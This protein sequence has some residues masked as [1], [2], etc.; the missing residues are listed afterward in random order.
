[1]RLF[2][3]TFWPFKSRLYTHPYSPAEWYINDFLMLTLF[4]FTHTKLSRRKLWNKQ[5][6]TRTSIRW[7]VFVWRRIDIRLGFSALL[8]N[9]VEPNLCLMLISYSILLIIHFCLGRLALKLAPSQTSIVITSKLC[10]LWVCMCMCGFLWAGVLLFSCL[11]L[12]H[13]NKKQIQAK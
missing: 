6:H 1:M 10:T 5:K 9:H 8:S 3:F 11:M 7:L 13:I 12:S 4:F 2:L